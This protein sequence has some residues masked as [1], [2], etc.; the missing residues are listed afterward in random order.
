MSGLTQ[1]M[2]QLFTG[3]SANHLPSEKLQQC[4]DQQWDRLLESCGEL[5]NLTASLGIHVTFPRSTDSKPAPLDYCEIHPAAFK[6]TNRIA[7]DLPDQGSDRVKRT[8]VQ[9]RIQHYSDR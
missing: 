7:N 6:P 8:M 9:S 1:R 4:E 3:R 5:L 2:Q